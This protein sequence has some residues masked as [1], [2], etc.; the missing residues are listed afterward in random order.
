MAF[1]RRLEL[2]QPTPVVRKEGQRFVVDHQRP[3]SVGRVRSF[4]GNF[5]M[6]VRAYTYI[7]ELGPEGLRR[8]SE[9]AVLNANYIAAR[10]RNAMPL[11]FETPPL[12][13]AV[14]TDRKLEADTAS[15]NLVVRILALCPVGFLILFYLMD[16]AGI[17]LLFTTIL[18]NIVLIIAG[19]LTTVAVLWARA[20]LDI[21]GNT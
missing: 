7:R 14:F 8:V 19:A 2:F 13:E 10:L 1:K 3:Q 21:G 15:G 11:A 5:G 9:M 18:G 12:H 4:Y 17:S 20:I 16:P 6:M